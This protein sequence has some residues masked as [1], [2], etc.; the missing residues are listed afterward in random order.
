MPA[1]TLARLPCE[2][3]NYRM[4][5][6]YFVL[7]LLVLLA[8]CSAP[9][10]DSSQVAPSTEFS[11]EQL[12]KM[13]NN[14]DQKP[15]TVPTVP[16]SIPPYAQL[17]KSIGLHVTGRHQ[18]IDPSTYRLKVTGKVNKPLELTYDQIRCLPK[19]TADPLLV[20]TGYFE[21][22]ASW[23]GARLF[24]ILKIAEIDPDATSLLLISA[25][26][27]KVQLSLNELDKEESILAYEVNDQILP[28][29]HGFP[30]RAVLPGREGFDWIKWL[31]EIQ[32]K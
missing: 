11:S 6:V 28:V 1:T 26:L 8:S 27:Y 19:V 15:F 31:V 5:K 32:V 18:I 29:L 16:A 14:C 25:D 12:L 20:C 2:N 10:A 13:A 22:Q 30:L 23:T 4:K 3:Y 9:T 21:D 7:I 17:D 24:D